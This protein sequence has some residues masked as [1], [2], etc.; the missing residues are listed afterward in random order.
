MYAHL[1]LFKSIFNIIKYIL[2]AML[3]LIEFQ[4]LFSSIYSGIKVLGYILS[5]TILTLIFKVKKNNFLKMPLLFY[6]H[7]IIVSP[8]Y[9]C[10][11]IDI[12]Q[13]A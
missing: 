7:N 4:K 12:F 5:I 6:I 8:F 3:L 2:M 1:A 11:L 10:S 13:N 9:F